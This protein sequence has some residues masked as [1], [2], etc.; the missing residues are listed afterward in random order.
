MDKVLERLKTEFQSTEARYAYAD[1]VTNA[2]LTA[3]IKA[4]RED[5]RLTQEKLAELVGTKQSGISRWQ[6]SGYSNCKVESLR[7]FAEA[8]GVRLRIRFE[9]FGTLPDEVNGFDERS[10]TPRRFE[11]DPAFNEP[12][13]E[14][15]KIAGASAIVA[16][17]SMDWD[18]AKYLLEPSLQQ[19][20]YYPKTIPNR[21]ELALSKRQNINLAE[22]SI[23]YLA[24][25]VA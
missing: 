14:L 13:K 16:A 12:S 10:L 20:D 1:S 9:E 18:W 11:D 2:F 19:A 7:K 17:Q 25:K 21:F 5:R 8:F 15:A 22:T 6:N 24:A 4:L 23:D 3:Q